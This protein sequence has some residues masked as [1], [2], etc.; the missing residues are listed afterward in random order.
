[1]NGNTTLAE[2]LCDFSGF[3][4]SF[5]AFQSLKNSKHGLKL[6]GLTQFSPEQLFFIQYAQVWCEISSEE[7]DRKSIIDDHS[8][9]RFR[10]MGIV[11]NSPQFGPLFSCKPGSPMNPV[12][13]CHLWAPQS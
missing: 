3:Q 13:K 11:T 6:P 1:M 9:G 7:G 4:Q 2:N 12:D 5:R 10:T 8:P